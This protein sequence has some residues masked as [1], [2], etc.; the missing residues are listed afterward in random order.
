MRGLELNDDTVEI[1]Q[2]LQRYCRDIEIDDI[3]ER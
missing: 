3:V 1:L 2:N